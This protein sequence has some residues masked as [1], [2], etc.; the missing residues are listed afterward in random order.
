MVVIV[1]LS[2]LIIWRVRRRSD[3]VGDHSNDKKIDIISSTSHDKS[4]YSNP[5]QCSDIKVIP[6]SNTSDQTTN[7]AT[8]QPS[9]ITIYSTNTSTKDVIKLHGYLAALTDLYGIE[10]STPAL[11]KPRTLGNYKNWLEEG[12]KK[13][14]AVLLLVNKQCQ[15]EWNGEEYDNGELHLVNIFKVRLERASSTKAAINAYS[16]SC[17]IQCNFSIRTPL[18]TPL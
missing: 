9:I 17:I 3:S 11:E 8:T 7:E 2:I 12:L 18:R 14:D 15:Q 13:K 4:G 1:T 6:D 16:S 5:M 10:V